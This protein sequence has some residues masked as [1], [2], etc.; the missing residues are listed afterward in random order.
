[1]LPRGTNVAVME[2]A[3][4]DP[5]SL[6]VFQDQVLDYD[7]VTL[8]SGQVK[9]HTEFFY[10]VNSAWEST[11]F[12]NVIYSDYTDMSLGKRKEIRLPP[13]SLE[14]AR[15]QDYTGSVVSM[16]PQFLREYITRVTPEINLRSWEIAAATRILNSVVTQIPFPLYEA[17]GAKISFRD[18][19]GQLQALN[20]LDLC[21]HDETGALLRGPGE[22]A[23]VSIIIP[24]RGS[25]N[26]TSGVAYVIEAITSLCAHNYRSRYEIV[27]V[28]DTAPGIDVTYLDQIRAVLDVSPVVVEWPH[29]FNFS[30]KVN[31]GAQV[32]QGEYLLFLNDDIEVS[33][34]DWLD[35]LV[36]IAQESDVGAVGALLRFPNGLIQHAGQVIVGGNA[37][38]AYFKS[39]K[40]SGDLADLIVDHE[41]V[42]V[43]GACLLQRTSVWRQV[44]GFS[45]VFPSNY[46][47]VDYCLKIW[48]Q[49]YRVVQANS[50]ELIHHESVT[51][52]A[53]VLST[54][55][56]LLSER[57]SYLLDGEDHYFRDRG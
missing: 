38:H 57:W 16:T 29:E 9:L 56:E 27:L 5:K 50:V 1:M 17:S 34:P 12:P 48:S 47:D 40:A 26:P 4:G 24:T 28:A 22:P 10:Y 41:V 54:D 11:N 14:R 20:E 19:P 8:I 33:T 18:V 30:G 2:I 15:Q 35:R 52:D 53:R 6:E 21:F 25:I 49:G 42:G 31:A 51:R 44:G 23:L 43:T 32:A 13:W 45:E 37:G 55:R 36:G 3:S 39:D 7:L 46:N